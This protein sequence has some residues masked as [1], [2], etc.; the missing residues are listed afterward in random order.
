MNFKQIKELAINLYKQEK[1]EEEINKLCGVP[2]TK[3]LISSWIQEDEEMERGKKLA[4]LFKKLQKLKKIEM[5][6]KNRDTLAQE[7][8]QIAFEILKIDEN[9]EI[10]LNELIRCFSL[11]K[12]YDLGR[13][14]GNKVL[15][16]NPK[17]IFTLYNMARLE[18]SAQN[19]EKAMEYNAQL[20][21]IEP[22]NMQGNTQ[23]SVIEERR[24]Q[25]QIEE[26]KRKRQEEIEEKEKQ[27]QAEIEQR[28]K[29]L[30]KAENQILEEIKQENVTIEAKQ[31]EFANQVEEGRYTK[32]NK[33]VYMQQLQTMFYEGKL[34]SKNIESVKQELYRY[35][36]QVESAIFISELYYLITENEEKGIEELDICLENTESLQQK[37][38][39]QLQEKR[40]DF[41]NRIKIKEQMEENQIKAKE[42]EKETK[43]K[44]RQYMTEI[45]TR[46]NEGTIQKEEVE[47]IVANL[48]KCLDRNKAV[49]LIIKV[50]EAVF[51]KAEALKTIQKYSKINNITEQERKVIVKMMVS[52][53]Q[54]NRN[55]QN[56]TEKLRNR[57]KI[58]KRRE[59]Y[60]KQISTKTI[61]DLIID[62]MSVKEVFEKMSNENFASLKSIAKIRSSMLQKNELLRSKQQED[63]RL[64]EEF[65]REGYSIRQVYELFDYNIGNNELIVLRKNIKERE[66][67]SK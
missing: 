37:E 17:N 42:Q 67:V 1:T 39:K 47:E 51:G 8:Q 9:N 31:E 48:E 10:A 50:Q 66:V 21:K 56:Y 38:K 33:E 60:K 11:Q 59:A 14:Y 16:N 26:Q 64:A 22:Q 6:A 30:E 58:R 5:T 28:V 40:K 29:Q 13:V 63:I 15:N 45:T 55:T 27:K 65:L 53:K 4:K 61:K 49:F 2:L 52:I 20:L 24:K 44:Q 35:P 46:L 41:L 62:G 18:I 3:E 57:T 43:N 7:I 19:Y 34:N 25:A 36:N 23:K 12:Q 54:G 32:E